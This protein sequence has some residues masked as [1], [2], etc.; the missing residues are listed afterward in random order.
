MYARFDGLGQGIGPGSLLVASAPAGSSSSGR[1]GLP[2][3]M[4][5]PENPITLATEVV[6]A[7]TTPRW[8][9][10]AGAAALALMLFT[11]R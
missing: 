2:S 10:I 1:A 6:H 9:W 11:R 3:G 8:L 5:T 4:G 7:T